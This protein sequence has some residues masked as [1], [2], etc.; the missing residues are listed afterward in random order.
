MTIKQTGKHV[1]LSRTHHHLQIQIC[2]FPFPMLLFGKQ[3]DDFDL[4]GVT[5]NYTYKG[6]I[7][8][9]TLFYGFIVHNIFSAASTP[10]ALIGYN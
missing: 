7:L 8:V 3:I 6:H 2:R 5:L 1:F 10:L 9:A 4:F